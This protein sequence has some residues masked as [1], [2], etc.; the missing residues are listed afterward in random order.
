MAGH[1]RSL[2]LN[3]KWQD[4]SARGARSLRLS[5]PV[6]LGASRRRWRRPR[7][8]RLPRHGLFG[9]RERLPWEGG[10][11]A[12]G[13]ASTELAAHTRRTRGLVSFRE[14]ILRHARFVQS[15]YLPF[16]V[17]EL[18]WGASW[19][20]CTGWAAALRALPGWAA[21]A[22]RDVRAAA[23]FAEPPLHVF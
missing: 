14:G 15:K 4:I 7:R 3:G 16:F 17:F 11:S 6:A 20:V 1:V 22:D 21:A 18:L 13:R 19:L 12:V 23:L 2:F 8:L 9:G 10:S 5:P